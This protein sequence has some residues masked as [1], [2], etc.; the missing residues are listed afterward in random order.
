MARSRLPHG[1]QAKKIELTK[2]DSYTITAAD[3]R[4]YGLI[5]QTGSTK[6]FTLPVVA[7][8]IIGVDLILVDRGG[9]ALKVV[10]AAGFAGQGA[11][12]DT[13][14]VPTNGSVYCYGDGT[15]WYVVG[16][17]PAAT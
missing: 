11:N 3:C 16:A 7:S 12:Y 15:Y 5:T 13:V 8:S 9:S 14:D 10:V 6:I 2:S 17:T 4:K 1:I